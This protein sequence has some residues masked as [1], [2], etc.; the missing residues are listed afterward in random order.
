MSAPTGDLTRAARDKQ[1][2]TLSLT[3]LRRRNS[4]GV[5]ARI[6]SYSVLSKHCAI[7]SPSLTR[8]VVIFE[9]Y[10]VLPNGGVRRR[11]VVYTTP[12]PTTSRR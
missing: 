12:T 10:S 5:V 7:E 4:A 6:H 2:V 11:R 1:I 9:R 3:A 8:R